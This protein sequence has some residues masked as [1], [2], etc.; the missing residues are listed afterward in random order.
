MPR[1]GNAPTAAGDAGKARRMTEVRS[2][3]ALLKAGALQNAIFNSANFSSIATDANGV[4]QIFNVGAERMLGYTAA[5]VLNK[6]TPADISDP[7][8]LVARAM[9]LSTELATQI[10]PG[11]EAL[12]F[13]ASRGI[14]DIYELTYIRKDGSRFPA[15]VSVTA[16]RD[17]H[18]AVIG[19]LLIGTD[20]T[21]RNLI[22]VERTKLD[23]A[24]RHANFELERAKVVAE[25]ASLAKS[26][27]LAAMS[28]EIRT[29]MNGVIGMIDVLQQSSLN[30]QQIEMTNII[31][32]SAFALLAVINDILDFSKIEAGKLEIDSVPMC[33]AD[34]VDGVCKVMDI[35]ALKKKVE[36]TL[37]T[38]PAIPTEVIGDPGRL[39]QILTNLVSN[40]VK[41][42]SLQP[43]RGRVSVRAMLVESDA[44]RV[45]LEF[46][47]ADN[48]IGIDDDTLKRLFTA[49]IQADNST[50]RKFGG[51]GLG[52]AISRQLANIMGGEITVH[53]KPGKGSRFKA[54][55]PFTLRGEHHDAGRFASRFAASGS[56][57]QMISGLPCLVV[58]GPD[59]TAD[60]LATYLAYDKAVVARATDLAAARQWIDNHPPGPGIIVVDTG[61]ASFPLTD[62][63]ATARAH[64]GN[65][66]H[67]IV[68]GRGWR[69][70]RRY[71][72][73][74]LLRAE[75]NL[76]THRVLLK[77]VAAAAD[78]AMEPERESSPDDV[79]ATS[80][81][82]STVTAV[83]RRRERILVAEDYEINQK[84]ILR[85]L[86]L[87]GFSA[88][89]IV[90]GHDA[91]KCWRRGDYAMLLTDLHMPEM[92]G[93]GLTAAI[94]REEGEGKRLPIVAVTA[95]ALKEVEAHCKEVGMDDYLSKPVLL[96]KLKAMLEKWLPAP[97]PHTTQ[98]DTAALP[99][100]KHLALL[101]TSVLAQLVGDDPAVIADFL[102]DYQRSAQDM[103]MRIQSALA[104]GDWKAVRDGAHKL[105]S[106]S[107]SVGALDLGDVCARLEHAGRMAD[108]EAGQ[109]LASEF[110][111]AM[112][113]VLA[114]IHQGGH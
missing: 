103:A 61:I 51:T 41:F 28:H 20:N 48:G 5:E 60:D 46:Q 37:F 79:N 42:S 35:M 112:T 111:N 39:R 53:S 38:D 97:D 34:V 22:E 49:F 1:K 23:Q 64:P 26:E 114:A 12:I 67:L 19:Y 54:S 21:A 77:A 18:N 94:R 78:R 50:T 62:L 93:F 90:N 107:L 75:G 31:H 88:D 113:G 32:E 105:K 29:P 70:G 100:R 27:F 86:G 87:L 4:I 91:L 44:Q 33:V 98:G 17:A 81:A 96:D 92:D 76:L 82:Q 83:E 45:M 72:H 84:V 59:G 99:A 106:S 8:E 102:Q 85:Q 66:I 69:H 24:L 47:V 7:Q 80:P 104:L 71:V 6:I 58:G 101:D 108:A 16:L 56:D 2:R 73:D 36:L 65:G 89:V 57:L 13:K 110:G 52:L 14:E 10:A 55:I 74:D 68:V 63:L 30:A 25:K 40:A 3:E 15:V 43:R 109:A 11:F 95:N 9:A